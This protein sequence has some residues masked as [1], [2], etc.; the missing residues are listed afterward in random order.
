M[1]H[2]FEPSLII[3]MDDGDQYLKIN[4]IIMSKKFHS[5]MYQI[6]INGWQ[7]MMSTWYHGCS[8]N[9]IA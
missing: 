9:G 5:G 7:L 4:K 8:Y 2:N 6:L 3:I 1:C